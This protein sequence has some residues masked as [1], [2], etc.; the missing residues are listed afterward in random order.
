M[1]QGFASG[2]FKS[3]MDRQ[4]EIQGSL[5]EES[6][7]SPPDERQAS[8]KFIAEVTPYGDL[9][10]P[11]CSCQ[12]VTPERFVLKEG[13]GWCPLCKKEFL[14]G[15]ETA[16]LANSKKEFFTLRKLLNV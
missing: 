11:S 4:T 13:R 16:E 8:I 10:C 12:I 5:T 7:A 2:E 9:V 14:L 1:L 3:A 6:Q 15:K